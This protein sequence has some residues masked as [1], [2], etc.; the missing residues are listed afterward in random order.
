MDWIAGAFELIGSWL[1][2]SKK[3]VG[4][5]FNFIGCSVWIYVAIHT[6]IYGLLLVVVP[7]IFI[8]IRNYIK[9]CK[10]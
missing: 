7:A 8:N 4:F 9:W 5:V 2:G 1:I 3:K 6:K 10:K